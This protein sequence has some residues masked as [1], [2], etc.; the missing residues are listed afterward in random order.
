MVLLNGCFELL[1][2]YLGAALATGVR[3]LYAA[4][5]SKWYDVLQRQIF[6]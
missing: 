5:K 3:E 1:I 2:D 4:P 6:A